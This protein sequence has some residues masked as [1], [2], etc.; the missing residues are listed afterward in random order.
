[1]T[2]NSGNNLDPWLDT[3]AERAHTLS[4]SEVRALFAVVSRPEVVSLAGGMPYVAALPKDVLEKSY[5]SLM[6]KKGDLAIQY[7]GGQGDET[8]RD[9]I[10]ELMALEGIRSS[11]EDLVITTGSQHGLELLSGIFLN[12]GDVVLAEGPS[13][14]GALGIFR[15]YQAHVEHVY[16]DEDGMSPEALEES[17]LRLKEAGRTIKF[18]Y[19]VPNFANPSGV[20]LAAERRPKILE[21]C[22]KHH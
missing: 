8:L 18:L 11:V 9:Q 13:Y 6:T 3:Y 16:T 14:V 22:R 21:I 19:L 1:M 7:G 4:V 5:N 12:E 17:I 10:R 2:N 15:H 20:T